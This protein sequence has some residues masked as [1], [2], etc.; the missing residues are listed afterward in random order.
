M[1]LKNPCEGLGRQALS[2]KPLLYILPYLS[3]FFPYFDV[4]KRTSVTKR[5]K[6]GKREVSKEREEKEKKGE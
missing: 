6:Y 2:Y 3:W 1:K 5:A 4:E